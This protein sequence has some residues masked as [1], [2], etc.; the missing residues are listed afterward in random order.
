MRLSKGNPPYSKDKKIGDSLIW[1]SLLSHLEQRKNEHPRVIFVSNDKNAW[2][3]GSFD[4]WLS[5][6]YVQTTG[7]RVIFSNRL[8]EIPDLTA[9]EQE[10]LRTEETEN[11][12]KNAVS[13]FVASHSFVNAGSTVLK[14]LRFKHVLTEDDYKRII[15][16]AVSNHEIYQSFF[17]SGPLS[18]LLEGENGYVIKE[19]E[20]APSEQWER[21]EK[22]YKTGLK[23]QS[24]ENASD[25]KEFDI[26][27]E[28]I[29]F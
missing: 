3:R 17:T 22:R 7:G 15:T 25:L 5:T 24:S 28:D 1:E 11:L 19:A 23:R 9:K 2:G 29:P 21:F 8:S 14:L 13:D 26:D 16:A 18:Q 10:R 4:P 27:P 6:E 20:S 12:K